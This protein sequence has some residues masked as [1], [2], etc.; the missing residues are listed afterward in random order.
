MDVLSKLARIGSVT[1]S[2]VFP[3]AVCHKLL[4]EVEGI[5]DVGEA[6]LDVWVLG[7]LG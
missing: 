5:V 6:E 2:A 7:E 4:L 1:N 3:V